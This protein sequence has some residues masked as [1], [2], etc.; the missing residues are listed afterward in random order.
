MLK[1]SLWAYHFPIADRLVLSLSSTTS[2]FILHPQ[3]FPRFVSQISAEDKCSTN[4]PFLVKL[5]KSRNHCEPPYLFIFPTRGTNLHILFN[6]ILPSRS[7][8]QLFTTIPDHPRFKTMIFSLPESLLLYPS[9]Q[10]RTSSPHPIFVQVSLDFVL[11]PNCWCFP[12]CFHCNFFSVA[13]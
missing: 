2:F 11:Q 10:P 7:S 8:T 4:N 5:P 6:F 9:C 13:S 1:L 3:L 12:L